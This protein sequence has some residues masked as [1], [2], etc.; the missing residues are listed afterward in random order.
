M[1]LLSSLAHTPAGLCTRSSMRT[2]GAR[3][4]AFWTSKSLNPLWRQTW[5]YGWF[6]LADLI[7]HFPVKPFEEFKEL[8]GRKAVE[9]PVHQVRHFGCL[10]P[11]STAISRCLS[12]P[13]F[14]YYI[15]MKTGPR[16]RDRSDIGNL[17]VFRAERSYPGPAS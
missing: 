2:P 7:G 11:S 9:M 6:M 8:V 15:H 16:K 14:Q 13:V 3:G 10:T 17:D 4:T 1:N 5:A 12:F